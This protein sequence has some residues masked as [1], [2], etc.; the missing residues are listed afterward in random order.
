MIAVTARVGRAMEG[1]ID[2]MAP[3]LLSP[4]APSLLLVGIPGVGKTTLL[5]ELARR[6]SDNRSL[7]VVIVDKTNELGGECVPVMDSAARL[8]L[9]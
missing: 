3:F 2:R 7:T 8:R 4:D 1:V 6:L 9:F 5:R